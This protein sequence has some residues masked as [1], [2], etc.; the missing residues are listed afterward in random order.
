MEISE[1]R[2]FHQ[3]KSDLPAPASPFARGEGLWVETCLRRIY[4]PNQNERD[5]PPDGYE[6][7]RGSQAYEFLLR[8]VAGLESAV[9]G[10][11]DVF[12]QVREAWKTHK[13]HGWVQRYF[14]DV[15]EIRAQ[16]LQG[17]GVSYGSLARKLFQPVAGRRIFVLGAGDMARALV[18]YLSEAEL[19]IWNRTPARA[20]ELLGRLPIGARASVLKTEEDG[21]GLGQDVIVCI[22]ADPEQDP[23][24]VRARQVLSAPRGT[25]LHL[26]I[27]DAQAT[28]WAQLPELQT[29]SDLFRAQRAQD[30]V[31]DLQLQRAAR[32]CREKAM[33][34]ALGG[35][36]SLAHGWED[37][38]IFG[39]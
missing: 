23:R 34:R 5:A 22:P 25:L 14:E 1:L 33:L 7:V 13:S 35:S 3:K 17:V 39:V 21:W 15:R 37:L 28:A 29:L 26:G 16:H 12:G 24:R 2:L 10:E 18:P 27:L 19:L 30:A 9:A 31:R 38:A 32:A 6:T 8:V 4:I 36:T 20:Y 11:T